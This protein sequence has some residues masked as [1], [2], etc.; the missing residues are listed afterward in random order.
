MIQLP[1]PDREAAGQDLLAALS[2]YRG[3]HPLVFGIP[4]GGVPIARIVADGL[5]GDLDVILVRKLGAPGNPE[6]AIGA[7]DEHGSIILND[8]AVLADASDDYIQREAKAQLGLIQDRRASY[9]PGQTPDL[10]GRT[11]IL[12]DDG[13]ATGATMIAGLR[14]VRTQHPRRLVCAVPVAAPESLRE[15]ARIADEVVCLAA[16]SPFGAVGLYYEDFSPVQDD[17][18]ASAL[19]RPAS[20]E[21]TV[22]CRAVRIPAGPVVLDGDLNVPP[23][24]VGLVVFAHGSGSSRQSTRNR[25]VAGV[26][27]NQRIATLLFDLL[28][29]QEDN[30]R[31][32]RFDIG[33]LA[34][35][36]EAALEWSRQEPMIRDWPIGLFGASTGA[37]AALVVAASRPGEVTAVVSRGGRPDLAGSWALSRVCMPVLLIVGGADR[38]VLALNREAQSAMGAWA[39]LVVIAGASHLFEEPGTLAQAA[40]AAAEWFARQFGAL[41]APEGSA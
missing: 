2:K 23:S 24:A 1:F 29:P 7:V 27:N 21:G 40:A 28:T 15:V 32:N 22:S 4:R 12:V 14:S 35:R 30:S 6:V 31:D 36:L 20:D 13:L 3:T 33:L 38:D 25:F 8:N 17:E 5:G 19:N 9:G 10:A 41:D 34:R 37:A 26:L 11:V 18:V 39:E 16:P